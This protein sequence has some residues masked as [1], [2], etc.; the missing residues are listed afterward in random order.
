[1]RRRR[2]AEALRGPLPVA[3]TLLVLLG[4]MGLAGCGKG[5]PADP[6]PRHTSFRRVR[7]LVSDATAGRLWVIDAEDEEVIATFDLPAPVTLDVTHT[8]AHGLLRGPDGLRFLDAG[9]TI[10]DHDDHIHIYKAQPRL[11]PLALDRGPVVGV[12]SG[13]GRIAAAFG[14]PAP[15]AVLLD[16]AALAAPDAPMLRPI[17]PPTAPLPPL[18]LGPHIVRVGVPGDPERVV[19]APAA[20]EGA[21][22][23]LGRCPGVR[24]ARNDDRR[25]A[26]V[27][28]DGLLLITTDAGAPRAARLAYPAGLAAGP[29]LARLHARQAAVLVDAGPRGFLVLGDGEAARPLTPTPALTA[30]VCDFD[31]DTGEDAA[32]VALGADGRVHHIRLANGATRSTGPLTAPFAC[33]NATRPR[34]AVAPERAYVS[35]PEGGRVHDVDL[36]TMTRA[37]AY[38]L[39]GGRPGPL[40]VLGVDP[41]NAHVAPGGEHGPTGDS[42][43]AGSQD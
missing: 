22:I 11:R 29:R 43:D 20:G 18:P 26:L 33:A 40:V 14:G 35:D 31:L 28:E 12:A 27:C 2:L 17:P 9:V 39:A 7:V 23:E 4:T 36:V 37:R 30:D 8:G 13:Q 42:G 32:L 1:V 5:T 25:V 3:A 21:E 6:A 16:E 38:P 10:V 24:D 34:L 15:S 19:A 41:K